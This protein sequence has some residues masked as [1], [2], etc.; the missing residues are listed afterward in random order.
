MML[1]KSIG[2]TLP[3]S[4][5]AN[6]HYAAGMGDDATKLL[7]EIR[8]LM[9]RLLELATQERERATQV[10]AERMG[11]IRE[12]MEV[13]RRSGSNQQ[14]VGVVLLGF[15]AALTVLALGVF[16]MLGGR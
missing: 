4:P 10:D 6:E 3:E 11:A 16:A 8:D 1:Q 14:R 15:V 7:A 12:L 2:S 9:V 5:A 13:Q